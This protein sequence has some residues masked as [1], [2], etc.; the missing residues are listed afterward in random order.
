MSAVPEHIIERIRKCF[1]LTRSSFEAE[2][3]TALAMAHKLMAEYGLTMAQVDIDAAG[4]MKEGRI[5]CHEGDRMFWQLWAWEKR[6]THTLRNLMSVNCIMCK[7]FPHGWRIAWVG[8]PEDAQL[9][10]AAYEILHAELLR[11]SKEE[12]G[13]NEQ[14]RRSYMEGCALTLMNRAYVMRKKAD[15]QQQK[16]AQHAR[17]GTEI[18]VIKDQAIKEYIKENSRPMHSRG[19]RTINEEAHSRG[20]Q[21][22]HKVSLSFATHLTGGK[23]HEPKQ[24]A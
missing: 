23:K 10:V 24:L 3:S 6:L 18:M 20:M 19:S 22:G 15:E 4:R 7:Q 11:M 17:T 9:A 16:S 21:A 2:S 1:A 13:R 8:T 14:L 12:C 5:R